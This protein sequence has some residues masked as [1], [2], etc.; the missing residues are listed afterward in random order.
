MREREAPVLSPPPRSIYRTPRLGAKACQLPRQFQ[1]ATAKAADAVA[2]GCWKAAGQEECCAHNESA[3]PSRSVYLLRHDG[4][5]ALHRSYPR[6]SRDAGK[7]GP[8]AP[9]RREHS[10]SWLSAWWVAWGAESGWLGSGQDQSSCPVLLYFNSVI[11]SRTDLWPLLCTGMYLYT[12]TSSTSSLPPL[13][14]DFCQEFSD[15]VPAPT[16]TNHRT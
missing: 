10:W 7:G 9:P 5:R 2:V 1:A 6:S 14:H 4:A 8:A 3:E 11:W 13:A 16:P 12:V 15:A